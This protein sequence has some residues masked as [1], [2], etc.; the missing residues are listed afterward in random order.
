[1][2]HAL[3]ADVFTPGPERGRPI[4]LG[5]RTADYPFY[6][7]DRDRVDI[8]R[9]FL[10]MSYDGPLRRD[11]SLDASERFDR[12]GWKR[13]LQSCRGTVATEAG[14]AVVD[15][16]DRT[17]LAVQR[18]L[19]EHPSAA[20]EEVH[21]RFFAE[22]PGAG[23]VSGKCVSSRHFDAIGTKTCQIMFRGRFNDTLR[24]D[25]HYLALERDFSNVEDVVARLMDDDVRLP[26]VNQAYEYARDG[27]THRHRITHLLRQIGG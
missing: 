3:N 21:Q 4:D 17:R 1:M 2:P 10:E 11:I 23:G 7:G 16:D 25:E 6:L 15:K 14:A 26:M 12:D 8:C 5:A 20:F 19:D 24:A 9:H 18:Y 22:R 27:H 13:F